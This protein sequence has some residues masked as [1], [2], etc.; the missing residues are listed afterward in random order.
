MVTKK[1]S[2]PEPGQSLADVNPYLTKQWHPTRN[3]ELTP[4]DVRVG[5]TIKAWWKCPKGDDHEWNAVIADRHRGI[6]CAICSNYKV[7]KSNSLATLNPDLA[8]EWDPTKNDDLTPDDVHPGS[9]KRV[10]LS[11]HYPKPR[12]EKTRSSGRLMLRDV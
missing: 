11:S 3:G 9:A 7:V 2:K 8:S 10:C 6:G 12:V 4:S 1:P 5:S